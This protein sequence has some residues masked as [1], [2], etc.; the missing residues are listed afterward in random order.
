[1][2]DLYKGRWASF[3]GNAGVRALFNLDDFDTAEYWSKF[4]GGRLI[5]S[6]SR[7][8]D[9]YG[10]SKGDNVGENM[11]PLLSSDTIMMAFAAGRMLV[12]AQGAHPI[13]TERVPYFRDQGLAGRWDDPRIPR[14]RGSGSRRSYTLVCESVPGGE[15]SA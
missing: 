6:R 13:V 5:E 1:M 10:Y 14:T 4:I 15:T 3:I 7:Q 9:I 12:L 11:R 2:R 8:Q